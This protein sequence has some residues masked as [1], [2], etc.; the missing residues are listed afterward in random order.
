MACM[1]RIIAPFYVQA[2]A[3]RTSVKPTSTTRFST[4]RPS[5][6]S[7]IIAAAIAPMRAPS[8]P[9]VA[10][11]ADERLRAPPCP[12]VI[13]AHKREAAPPG[14]PQEIAHRLADAPVVEADGHVD[15]IG[16]EVP[17]FH[18]RDAR[19]LQSPPAFGRML[20]SRKH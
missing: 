7:M 11:A 5:A 1:P 10:R 20:E 12:L 18:H 4:R 2:V 6:R 16:P 3:R 17:R 13:A 15:G 9:T 19:G 14:L 8:T